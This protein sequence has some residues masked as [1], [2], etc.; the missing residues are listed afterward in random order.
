MSVKADKKK[1]KILI[2]FYA[3]RDEGGNYL[4]CMEFVQDV[5]DFKRLEGEKRLLG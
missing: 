2:E 1:H 3:L 5:E 4:G